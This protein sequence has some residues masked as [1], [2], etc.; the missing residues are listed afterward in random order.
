[1][2]VK[3]EA[4]V[5]YQKQWCRIGRHHWRVTRL[6]ELTK[7]MTVETMPLRH[8]NIWGTYSE[9]SLRELAGHIISVNNAD[10]RYPIILDEDGEIMDGRHRVLKA[11]VTQKENIRFVRFDKNP[12]P[13]KTTKKG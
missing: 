12:K 2:G 7:N 3:I 4:F 5:N 6:I 13:C 8:L 9:M 1:M 11:L 10:L